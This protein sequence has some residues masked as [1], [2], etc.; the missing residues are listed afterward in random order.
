MVTAVCVVVRTLDVSVV[1]AVELVLVDPLVDGVP[2]DAAL[3][4]SA[5][6]MVAG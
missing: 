6:A 2:V 3:V 5:A 1:V 4:E